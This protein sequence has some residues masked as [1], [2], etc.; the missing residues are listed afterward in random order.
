MPNK[1]GNPGRVLCSAAKELRV[2]NRFDVAHEFAA[3]AVAWYQE[4]TNPAEWDYFPDALRLA[5][6]WT[7]ARGL[8]EE[9]IAED[10][11]E[12]EYLGKLGTVAVRSGDEKLAR[13]IRDTLEHLDLPYLNGEH[14]YWN[15]CISSL[16]NER[17]QAVT[18]LREAF[19]QG[20]VH[21]DIK[22]REMDLEPLRNYPPF[23]DLIRPRG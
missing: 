10:P 5:E 8:L 19:K 6:Q 21:P 23:Q 15:A 4:Q 7:E 18:L 2:Q 9:L 16:L 12:V 22:W 11:D 14:T 1:Y 20:L 17:E 3:R 13:E